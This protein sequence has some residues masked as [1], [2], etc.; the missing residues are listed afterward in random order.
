M[1]DTESLVRQRRA[2]AEFGIFALRS[3]D[4]AAVM[5]EASRQAAESLGIEM[6]KILELRPAESSFL[7]CSGYGLLPGTVGEA[8]I[9]LG[10]GS[11][12]GMAI[13]TGEPIICND[14][15]TE[16]RFQIS[17][18]VRRHGVRSSSNVLISNSDGSPYGVL[19]LDS[20]TP[21]SF[22]SVD[23]PYLQ[24]YANLV[25]AAL[26]R[27]RW[28]QRLQETLE[29]RDMLM[30]ELQHRVRNDLQAVIGLLVVEASD[31][32]S[33]ETKHRFERVRS[34]VNA[35]RLVHDR[36]F[37]DH[38]FGRVDGLS[39]LG[40]LA[41]NCID[42]WGAAQRLAVELQI[43]GTTVAISHDA[44][45]TLGLIVNEFITNS[46]KYAFPFGKGTIAIQLDRES[47]SSRYRLILSDNGIG[48]P[49]TPT[50]HSGRRFIDALA[51]QIGADVEWAG[52]EGVRLM[53]G[54]TLRP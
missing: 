13:A 34:R 1:A 31:S 12:A 41:R 5:F 49:E 24:N 2:L 16:T 32:D 10:K 22:G 50:R 3:G 37:R 28:R 14:T 9:P 53:L 35:L 19:E 6:A 44:A 4:L 54:F 8:R 47:D 42:L 30:R 20:R 46:I 27:W 29:E 39:Y 17:E 21:G 36:L 15:L 23:T 18:T 40:D 26:E 51:K 25:G 43:G 38:S 33:A 45:V 11:A 7:V 52:S 48:F